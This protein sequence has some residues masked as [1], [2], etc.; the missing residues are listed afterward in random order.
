MQKISV[1]TVIVFSIVSAQSQ[2][3]SWDSYNDP[4]GFDSNYEYNFKALPLMSV[5]ELSKRPWSESY[6]PR[7]KG[8]INIRWNAPGKPGFDYRSPSKMDV[9]GVLSTEQLKQ[10][11]PSEKFDL[12]QGHYDYPLTRHVAQVNAKRDA[13]D[14]EG[15]CDGWTAT[16]M[17]FVEPKPVEIRNPEGIMIPFGSSDVK[18]LMAYHAAFNDHLGSVIIGRYCLGSAGLAVNSSRCIDLNTGAFHV[19]LANEICLKCK[20]FAV[21][22]DIRKETWNQPVYGFEFTIVGSAKS[23]APKA[24]QIHSKMMYTDE[25]E[26]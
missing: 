1:F 10:L 18:A 6:W 11:S 24:V 3:D 25:L 16:A 19:M 14:F 7:N 12:A 8:S 15:I 21:D 13:K 9:M 23:S 17:Q 26:D 2:A 22:V 4:S 5:L 20:L